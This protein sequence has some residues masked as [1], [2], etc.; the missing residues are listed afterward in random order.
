[1]LENKQTKSKANAQKRINEK[2]KQTFDLLLEI[3]GDNP[4][5]AKKMKAFID[6]L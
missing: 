5:K 6:A 3:F 1:M 2:N 4:N